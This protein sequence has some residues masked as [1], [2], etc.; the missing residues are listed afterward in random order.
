MASKRQRESDNQKELYLY[1]KRLRG[2]EYDKKFPNRNESPIISDDYDQVSV[3]ASES[4]I[5][6]I[7]VRDKEEIQTNIDPL[8]FGSAGRSNH[9]VCKQGHFREASISSVAL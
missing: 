8:T 1:Q 5:V 9:H 2:L 3:Y 7:Q 4:G 6:S